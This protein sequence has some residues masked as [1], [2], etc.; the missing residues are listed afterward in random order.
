MVDIP[1]SMDSYISANPNSVFAPHWGAFREKF[2]DQLSAHNDIALEPIILWSEDG[3]LNLVGK[4]NVAK[5]YIKF[6]SYTITHYPGQY[7][8]SLARNLYRFFSNF[9]PSTYT[10]QAFSGW[11][12]YDYHEYASQ[13]FPKFSDDIQDS[14]QQ[15]DRIHVL[16]SPHFTAIIFII[17]MIFNIFVVILH[18]MFALFNKKI[19]I[20]AFTAIVFFIVN[21][22]VSANFGVN[23]SD[24][25][26]FIKP[27]WPSIL[28]LA[29]FVENFLRTNTSNFLA[30]IIS[31]FNKV[32]N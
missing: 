15:L 7:L 28:S 18:K 2:R 11:S 23:T 10:I 24:G 6:V 22:F 1:E 16:Y 29:L 20:M 4:D 25:R 5:E 30:K 32:T 21:A 17:S 27:F 8:S 13:Y 3:I 14:A 9:S 19:Y 31:N 26:F 12:S